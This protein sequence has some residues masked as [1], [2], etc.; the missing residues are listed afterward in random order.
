VTDLNSQP[1]PVLE[2]TNRESQ[3]K[4][5]VVLPVF[6]EEESVQI[7]IPGIVDTLGAQTT[8]FEV[9]AID[10]GSSDQTFKVLKVIQQEHP[11]HLRLARH[12][13][14]KGNGAALRTGIRLARG[15]L[16]LAHAR[17]AMRGVGIAASPTG[18]TIV[19]R[20]G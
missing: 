10:D 1:A 3:V 6:N 8:P 18:F 12:I 20:V 7:L 11:A 4:V 13:T 14:N 9:I 19:L 17:R 5:S 16:L 15:D 2:I